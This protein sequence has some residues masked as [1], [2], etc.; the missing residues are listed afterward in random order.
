MDLCGITRGVNAM[1]ALRLQNRVR[2]K[3]ADEKLTLKYREQRKE[4]RGK[5]IHRGI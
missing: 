1:R 3:T 2:V 5:S 4:K